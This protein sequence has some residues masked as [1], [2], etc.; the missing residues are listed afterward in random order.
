[1]KIL[2]FDG[3]V[4]YLMMV[5]DRT[6]VVS[7]L[8]HVVEF[9]NRVK[10]IFRL[11]PIFI[12]KMLLGTNF[13]YSL[14]Q[15]PIREYNNFIFSSD[16]IYLETRYFTLELQRFFSLFLNYFKVLM[17][18]YLIDIGRTKLVSTQVKNA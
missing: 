6:I 15:K 8:T 13:E 11:L 9:C 1:M 7:K 16:I 10:K 12:F 14:P 2:H 18:L 3:N 4:V 17:A 5:S